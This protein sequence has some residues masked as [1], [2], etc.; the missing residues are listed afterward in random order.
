MRGAL[1]PSTGDLIY[2]RVD[3]NSILFI[4]LITHSK[5]IQEHPLSTGRM[6]RTKD[7]DITDRI[8]ICAGKFQGEHIFLFKS[9]VAK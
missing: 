3:F 2:F 7:K 4:W 1:N 9:S 6:L 8:Q 5:L